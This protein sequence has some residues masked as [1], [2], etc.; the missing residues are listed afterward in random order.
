MPQVIPDRQQATACKLRQITRVGTWNTLLQKG[1]LDNNKMEMERLNINI[2]GL[3]EVRWKGAND[4]QTGKFRFLCSGGATH[5]RGV[6]LLVDQEVSKAVK[7]YRPVSDRVL[8]LKISGKPMDLNIIQ[9]HAPTS[10]SSEEEIETF[11][12]ELEKAINKFLGELEEPEEQWHQLKT[13]I[14][15]AA[16]EEIPPTERRAR[17]RW[18]TNEILEIMDKRKQVKNDKDAYETLHK[19]I[20][21]KCD[22]AKE[23]WLNEKCKNMDLCGKRKPHMIYKNTEEMVGR[24]T[25]SSTGCLKAKNG[26]IIIKKDKILERWA[27]YIHELFDD[28][29]KHD[30][31]VMKRNFAG[32]PIMKDEARAAIRKM[33]AG[34]ATGPDGT[35]VEMI[36]ALEEYGVEKLTSLLN[37][38]YDTG[39]IPTDISRSVFIAH[40]KKPGPTECKLHRTISLMSHVTKILLRV[41]M[42]RIRSKI[43]PEI[44][45]EQYGFV[46]GKGTTNAIYTLRTLIQR[47]IEVQKDFHL[48][49]IDYRKTFDR[50]RHDEIMKDLTQIKI[51]G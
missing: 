21:K 35:A 29:R 3:S 47:A 34:K 1:K 14:T 18:M 16:T 8:L 37:E 27:E 41:V 30:H 2:L 19:Q 36:E 46:E 43:K 26:N 15:K 49:F 38:I 12:E 48:C 40:P 23:K 24:K 5:E 32:P 10:T 31:N 6:G 7:G 17:Q 28:N 13:A 42:I 45:D 44:A 50:L 4:M 22:E 25:C 11:Y 39:E 33:K 20:R 9:V 51:D